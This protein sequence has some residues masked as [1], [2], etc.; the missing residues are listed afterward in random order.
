MACMLISL[1]LN[2]L[3]KCKTKPHKPIS[4]TLLLPLL[5][6]EVI[7]TVLGTKAERNWFLH[8]KYPLSSESG[9][10]SLTLHKLIQGWNICSSCNL[11]FYK[12]IK[13]L[14][15][16]YLDSHT[17]LSVGGFSILF[18]WFRLQRKYKK[19]EERAMSII[20]GN[21]A[22]GSRSWWRALLPPSSYPQSTL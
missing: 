20:I 3:L 11:I 15:G 6:S 19:H 9:H 1:A 2:F 7:I 10:L 12:Y 21:F 4:L 8:I 22:C 16:I 14:V 5:D 17:F 18:F 13:F